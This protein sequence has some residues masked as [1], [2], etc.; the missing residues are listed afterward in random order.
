[1]ESTPAPKPPK[2]NFAPYTFL[3]GTWTCDTKS[4]RRPAAYH[5]TTTYAFDPTGY[6]LVGKSTTKAMAWFPYESSGTDR[7]TYDAE[8]GRWIEAFNGTFGG[9]DLSE[10]KGWSGPT[11]VWHNLAFARGKDVASQRDLTITKVSSSKMTSQTTFT[12]VKGRS[13]G[14]TTNC[15]KEV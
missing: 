10:S 3:V 12:T 15:T 6:W 9:Y 14:V 13:V 11:L 5:T 4:A 8:T 2:P 1:M 7:I